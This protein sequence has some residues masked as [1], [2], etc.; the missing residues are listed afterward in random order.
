[1][2]LRKKKDWEA[3]PSIIGWWLSFNPFS[4]LTKLDWGR[5][6]FNPFSS[7]EIFDWGKDPSILFLLPW[8]I[9]WRA[10]SFIPFFYLENIALKGGGSFDFFFE[11]LNGGRAFQSFFFLR[12]IGWGWWLYCLIDI[13]FQCLFAFFFLKTLGRGS[14]N[15]TLFWKIVD[16][17]RGPLIHFSF[18]KISNGGR[19]L[20]ILFPFL[21]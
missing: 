8:N 21:K 18:L 5:G 12:N 6:T 9:G 2:S 4:F 16:G 19:C 1:M 10:G 7:L 20:S 14:F 13:V 3:T 17:E 11:I 15:P